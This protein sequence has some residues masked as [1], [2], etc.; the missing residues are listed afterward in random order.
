[1]KKD[2]QV[3]GGK[4]GHLQNGELRGRNMVILI[5]GKF[6]DISLN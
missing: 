1:M 3:S 4:I 6:E 2:T 5:T